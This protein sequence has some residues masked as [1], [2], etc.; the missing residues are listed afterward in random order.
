MEDA[1]LEWKQ[2]HPQRGYT[3]VNGMY[4]V[5]ETKAWSAYKFGDLVGGPFKSPSTSRA[6]LST[7][8][9]SGNVEELRLHA[10]RESRSTRF[11]RSDYKTVSC[12]FTDDALD[13]NYL[14]YPRAR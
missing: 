11:G 8:A 6:Q 13:L 4:E 1:M 5:R 12:A 7:C 9:L 2:S 10:D 3:T 14:N